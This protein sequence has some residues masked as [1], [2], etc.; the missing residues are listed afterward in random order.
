[1]RR[2]RAPDDPAADSAH[3]PGTIPP[4]TPYLVAEPERVEQW[5]QRLAPL[6]GFRVGLFW[7]GNKSH[8]SDRFRSL[9]LPTLEPLAA[10]PNVQLISLQKGA[11]QEQIG[12][13]PWGHRIADFGAEMDPGEDAFVDTAAVIKNLDLVITCDSVIAHLA[14]G[15]GTPPGRLAIRSGLRWLTDRTDTPWYPTMRLFRQTRSTTGLV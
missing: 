14:G 6:S 7:Q 3:D 1:M 8:S 5:R 9:P 4:A 11:G 2:P 10:I 15:L 12:Q 13:C